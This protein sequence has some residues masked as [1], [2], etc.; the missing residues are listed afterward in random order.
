LNCDLRRF[1]IPNF[2]D[3]NF[4]RILTQDG[5]QTCRKSDSDIGF[6]WNLNDPV[7]VVLNRILGRDQLFFDVILFGQSRI[8]RGGLA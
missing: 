6:N 4:V 1:E 5:P 3:K 2:P 8:Q 7:D